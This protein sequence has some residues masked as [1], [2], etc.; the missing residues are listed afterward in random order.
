[1]INYQLKIK[2]ILSTVAPERI[3][4]LRINLTKEVKD[5]YMGNY[6][7]LM[8]K[9]ENNTNRWQDICNHVLEELILLIWL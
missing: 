4:Y 5:L 1:M 2:K 7:K 6:E 3:K 9:I 8:K